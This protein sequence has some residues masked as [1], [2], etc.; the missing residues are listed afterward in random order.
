MILGVGEENKGSF[1]N[2]N[3]ILTYQL[4][5]LPVLSIQIE[6]IYSKIKHSFIDKRLDLVTYC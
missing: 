3:N 4:T 5:W 6:H 1:E 2:D